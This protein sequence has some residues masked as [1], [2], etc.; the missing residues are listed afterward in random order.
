MLFWH[1]MS[2][3]QKLIPIYKKLH[4]NNSEALYVAKT[5]SVMRNHHATQANCNIYRD[6]KKSGDFKV[7]IN[8]IKSLN[9]KVQIFNKQW[10]QCLVTLIKPSYLSANHSFCQELS[11]YIYILAS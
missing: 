3:T 4:K 7:V 8:N 6:R 2:I 11:P 10:K 5:P 9:C 1:S